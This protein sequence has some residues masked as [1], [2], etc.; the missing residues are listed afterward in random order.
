MVGIFGHTEDDKPMK[1]VSQKLRQNPHG[2]AWNAM[3]H[4][5]RGA[6]ISWWAQLDWHGLYSLRLQMK[7]SIMDDIEE[8][9]VG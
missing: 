6:Q 1:S 5:Y 4:E 7:N 3:S 9:R 8:V 2:K